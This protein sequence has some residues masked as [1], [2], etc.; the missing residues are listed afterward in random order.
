MWLRSATCASGGWAGGACGGLCG[1]V[2][3]RAAC[4]YAVAVGRGRAGG[5]PSSERRDGVGHRLTGVDAPTAAGGHPP[6]RPLPCV[7]GC[8]CGRP[9]D[10]PPSVRARVPVRA[11]PRHAPFRACAGAGAGGPPTRPLLFPCVRGC[12]R[13]VAA[14]APSPP[15]RRAGGPPSRGP[16]VRPAAG[17]WS[18]PL[19]A[20][21]PLR[22]ARVGAAAPR[23][24]EPRTHPA[25]APVSAPGDA[26]PRNPPAQ[27]SQAVATSGRPPSGPAPPVAGR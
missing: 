9:P 10:T 17:R 21:V 24:A 4:A 25:S 14:P 26:G 7:R 19:R 3:A 20:I 13:V 2:G 1:S 22:A 11:A 6:T 27:L 18:A 5:C 8:R 15:W 23:R 16:M 12:G